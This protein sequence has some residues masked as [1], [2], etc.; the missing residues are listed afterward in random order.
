MVSEP[1]AEPPA[2]AGAMD[3]R[4]FLSRALGAAG[5]AVSLGAPA[6]ARAATLGG[7][8]FGPP[9]VAPPNILVVIV[10]QMR[11]PCWWPPRPE[12]AALFPNLARLRAGAA[13]FGRHYTASNDCTPS[14]A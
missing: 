5:A 10:D 13:S 14:R 3:R 1:I 8:P 4:A 11:S 2:R 9:A 12:F 7:G 6:L